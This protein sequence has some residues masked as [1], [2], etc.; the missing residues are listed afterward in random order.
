VW[1]YRYRVSI[2]AVVIVIV[3]VIVIVVAES[4]IYFPSTSTSKNGADAH[5]QVDEEKD[6]HESMARRSFWPDRD[7]PAMG[8]IKRD[9]T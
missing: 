1:L 8:I 4:A 7:F 3:I 9:F 2:V 5:R 6:D